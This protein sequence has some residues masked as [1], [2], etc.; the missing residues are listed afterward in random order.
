MGIC[1]SPKWPP[2]PSKT[3]F[4][5]FRTKNDVFGP[6]G[7]DDLQND[8]KMIKNDPKND[9][10]P[11]K[12]PLDPS[13]TSQT[14]YSKLPSNPSSSTLQVT[15]PDGSETLQT[16]KY[17]KF[18]LLPSRTLGGLQIRIPHYS[19]LLPIPPDPLLDPFLAIFS[20]K[21]RF[22]PLRARKS[23]F[24]ARRRSFPKLWVALVTDP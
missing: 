14:S 13:W 4:W 12:W 23:H 6:L 11:E 10:K 15:R 9:Q 20:Q 16:K 18:D 22:L 21:W 5:P 8:R 1:F 7:P 2:G 17:E 19:I 3:S 24:C